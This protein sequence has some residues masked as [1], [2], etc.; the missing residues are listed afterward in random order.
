MVTS[1]QGSEFLV[2]KNLSWQRLPG[3]DLGRE[4]DQTTR[5]YSPFQ[6]ERELCDVHKRPVLLRQLAGG[7]ITGDP[8]ATPR[9]SNSLSIQMLL[10]HV[11][12]GFLEATYASCRTASR[13]FQNQGKHCS[14][15]DT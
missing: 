14:L 11:Q 8:T 4:D 12:P 1:L 7:P 5:R 15:L 10:R 9:P 3:R 13:A 6:P 2:T